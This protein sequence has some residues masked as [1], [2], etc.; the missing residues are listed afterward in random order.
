MSKPLIGIASMPFK[1]EYADTLPSDIKHEE[2]DALWRLMRLFCKIGKGISAAGGVPVALTVSDDGKYIDSIAEKLDGFVFSGGTSIEPS[3]Y[4]MENSSF[5]MPDV[6]RD[7]FEISLARKIIAMDKPFLG[8]CRGCQ[9]LNVA[10]GGSLIQYLP[11]IDPKLKLHF[12]P[13]VLHG[14]VHEVKII[15]PELFASKDKTIKVNSIHRQAIGKLG[16]GLEVSAMTEDGITE[17]VFMKN[18]KYI[19]AVQWHPEC[20]FEEDEV[21][22]SIFRSFVEASS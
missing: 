18:A 14:Y 22:M 16:A 12:R 3:F 4:A 13:D 17:G 9:L 7:A 20:L 8:F 10:C 6:K 15:R 1:V 5:G 19:R 21:Q 2:A 11:A